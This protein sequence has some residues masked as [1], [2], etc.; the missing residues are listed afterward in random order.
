[1]SL[2]SGG[3]QDAPCKTQQRLPVTVG[4]VLTS[5]KALFFPHILWQQS[6]HYLPKS[7]PFLSSV[8]RTFS[9]KHCGSSACIQTNSSQSF[10]FP[11]QSGSFCIFCIESALIQKKTY[12]VTEH[13]YTLILK[14]SLH[15]YWRVPWFFFHLSKSTYVQSVVNFFPLM[16]ISEDVGTGAMGDKIWATVVT[17]RW[18]DMEF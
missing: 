12:Q 17:R 8:Q 2:C 9:L 18:S 6:W 14:G 13:R 4:L 11:F 5:L 3:I 7:S 1:M 15:L 16:A 10:M